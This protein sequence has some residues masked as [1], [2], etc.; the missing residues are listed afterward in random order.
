M[1]P[2]PLA[3]SRSLRGGPQLPLPAMPVAGQGCM[4]SMRC[5]FS[6][7]RSLARKLFAIY[8]HMPGFAPSHFPL[9]VRQQERRYSHALLV[10]RRHQGEAGRC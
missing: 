9:F 4:S 8:S 3:R 2:S 6:S 1:C 7:W 10:L 5:L